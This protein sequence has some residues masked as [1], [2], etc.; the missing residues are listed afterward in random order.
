MKR[1]SR[2]TTTTTT[3][4][5]MTMR[6]RMMMTRL[7]ECFVWKYTSHAHGAVMVMPITFSIALFPAER[8]QHA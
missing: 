2:K 6:M 5:M 4:M 8:A 1:K 3:T 7:V